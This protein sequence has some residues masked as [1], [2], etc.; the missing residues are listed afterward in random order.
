MFTLLL[1]FTISSILII[2]FCSSTLTASSSTNKVKWNE[3]LKKELMMWNEECHRTSRRMIIF[4]ILF[5]LDW[6][7]WSSPRYRHF[8]II[9][10]NAIEFHSSILINRAKS[11]CHLNRQRESNSNNSKWL[12]LAALNSLLS[13]LATTAASGIHLVF[14]CCKT[15]KLKKERRRENEE[16]LL[17][18]CF[19]SAAAVL[20]SRRRRDFFLCFAREIMGAGR[21]WADWRISEIL[22]K[23]EKKKKEQQQIRSVRRKFNNA[24]ENYATS[25]WVF[26]H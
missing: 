22:L 10:C 17:I 16:K 24:Q 21:R 20:V 7:R 26:W 3:M 2:T 9:V 18:F 8:H 19:I 13:S 1:F 5:K 15:E 14:S 12:A 11:Q 4:F 23:N 6:L 25:V